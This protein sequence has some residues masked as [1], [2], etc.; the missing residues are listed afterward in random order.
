HVLVP[1]IT[2]S[3]HF[4]RQTGEFIRTLGNVERVEVLPYH[5]LGVY[6]WENLGLA[7]PL[8]DVLPPSSEE[9]N[10]AQTLLESYLC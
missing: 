7:Y 3:E 8:T 9:T 10:A 5:Q 4:L 6:K 1:G 2:M